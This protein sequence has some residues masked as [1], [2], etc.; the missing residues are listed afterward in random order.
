MPK[1]CSICSLPDRK[2][3]DEA[4]LAGESYM[5]L[6][7]RFGVGRRSLSRH[8]AVHVAPRVARA[9]QARE[10][11]AREAEESR[12]TEALIDRPDSYAEGL[13]AKLERIEAESRRDLEKAKA[14]ALRLLTAAEAA[15][16][17]PAAVAAIREYRSAAASAADAGLRVVDS[18][19]R[20]VGAVREKA[21]VSVNVLDEE[22]AV[23]VARVFLQRRGLL[24]APAP[25][26]EAEALPGRVPAA[27]RCAE[28][29]TASSG[30]AEDL[31]ESGPEERP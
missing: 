28:P 26:I 27:P 25:T 5:A 22:T 4:L 11:A 6:A 16:N 29:E 19:A 3:A 21:E 17:L 31:R 18:V 7:R 24:P 10:R 2:K 30:D 8:F 15:Q 23:R 13:L 12:Y 20:I 14:D 1:A 9:Q